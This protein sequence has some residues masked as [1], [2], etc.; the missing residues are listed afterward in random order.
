MGDGSVIVTD[1]W[2]FLTDYKQSLIQRNLL[3]LYHMNDRLYICGLKAE[4]SLYG[5]KEWIRP[6]R[7]RS[8]YS[9]G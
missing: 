1:I 7:G 2:A 3:I 5:G 8:R 9:S 6:Y 4:F